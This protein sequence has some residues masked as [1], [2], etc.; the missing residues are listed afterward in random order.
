VLHFRET[1]EQADIVGLVADFCPICRDIRPF[2]LRKI[3]KVK[4][5]GFILVAIP[6]VEHYE[7]TEVGCDRVCNICNLDLPAISAMY[8][9]VEP[10]T[11]LTL[12]ELVRE[13]NPEIYKKAGERLALE[14]RIRSGKLES[15]RRREFLLEP[16]RV[17][18]HRIR[19][20]RGS[21]RDS[22]SRI[23]VGALILS[24]AG[25]IV[26]SCVPHPVKDALQTICGLG[27]AGSLL[28]LIV[29]GCGRLNR[30]AKLGLVLRSEIYPL[31]GRA[32][33]PLN[34]SR[35]EIMDVFQDLR[36]ERTIS[37]LVLNP[38]SIVAEMD[39]LR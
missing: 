29:R 33:K 39:C 21:D 22:L 25:L 27:L 10:V 26:S 38:E 7:S 17:L 37:G 34:P 28:A 11:G 24:I 6:V 3:L 5:S 9:S 12:D 18:E 4:T 35:E 1:S 32:L 14:E 8:E 19:K 20:I 31:L 30:K 23:L 36:R 15:D 16:F 13:T 2:T